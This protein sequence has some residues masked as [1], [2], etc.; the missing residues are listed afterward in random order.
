MA[1]LPAQIP[2]LVDAFGPH[3]HYVPAGV[4]PPWA[5]RTGS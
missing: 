2:E 3:A 5:I 4:G 1:K